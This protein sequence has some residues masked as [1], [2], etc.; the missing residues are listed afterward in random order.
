MVEI[1]NDAAAAYRGAIPADRW[2]EPYMPRSE[3]EHEL[4]AG[5]I[6]SGWE[7]EGRL[8]GVMGLQAVKDVLLIRHAYVR[9]ALRQ[10]GIGGRL[11]EHLVSRADRRLL[12]G[13]WRDATWAVTFYQKHGFR[14]VGEE[15]KNRLLR[16]YWTIP[17]RQV[18]TSVVLVKEAVDG[19]ERPSR[20]G[21]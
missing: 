3:L 16:T 14:L 19:G 2:H 12:V 6:F 13:T 10:R 11:L 17:D 7:D 15:E 9:T 18:V 4:E 8:I 21:R 20:E 1:I 5:V